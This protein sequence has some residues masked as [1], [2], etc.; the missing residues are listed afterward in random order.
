[1]SKHV[2]EV[3]FDS[4]HASLVVVYPAAVHDIK[5]MFEHGQTIEE[6]A[7]LVTDKMVDAGFIAGRPKDCVEKV[8][9][10]CEQAASYGFD[11]I[12]FAKLG[13]DYTEA[14]EILGNDLL[15]SIG[16]R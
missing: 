13:P 3:V 2:A 7:S 15:P 16:L 6:A 4:E 1:M 5:Q 12:C 10:M 11:Q 8:E 9:E 14:I